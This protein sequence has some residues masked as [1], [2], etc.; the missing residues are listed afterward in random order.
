MKKV[1]RVI[2]IIF[3][4]ELAVAALGGVISS[5]QNPTPGNIVLTLVCVILAILL[6]RKKNIKVKEPE[7]WK[8]SE[9]TTPVVTIKTELTHPEVLQDTLRDMR[10]YYSVMQ[11]ENDARI[12]RESF[13]LCQQTYG[14]ETFLSRLQLAER[15]ALTL[16]QAEKAGCR[17]D[18]KILKAAESVLSATDALKVDF[19]GRV[20][21][22]ETTAAM[23][24]KTQAGV[25]RRL[26][27]FIDSLQEHENDFL[28]VEDDY[29]KIIKGVQALMS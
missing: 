2:R 4:I 12:M 6:L 1:L 20:Y 28:T 22:K 8:T 24:L 11:A 5:V 25:N 15:K 14:Y 26:Q 16:L 19:L 13:Q 10:R 7:V 23:H 3:G 9:T 17:V 18:A 29:N 27:S 21:T